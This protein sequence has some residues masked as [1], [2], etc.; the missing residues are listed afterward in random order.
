LF[1]LHDLDGFV[2]LITWPV[3][4]RSEIIQSTQDI[5]VPECRK[6]EIGKFI[7]D[8][9]VVASPA[10]QVSCQQVVFAIFSGCLNAWTRSIDA[11]IGFINTRNIIACSWRTETARFIFDLRP[12]SRVF[13]EDTG[14]KRTESHRRV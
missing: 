4:E 5:I 7:G 11:L 3:A 1:G 10:Q 8:E 6:Q 12:V 2:H 9:L 14:E 13:C